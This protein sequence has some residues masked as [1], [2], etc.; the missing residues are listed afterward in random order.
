[1]FVLDL[2][3]YSSEFSVYLEMAKDDLKLGIV[4]VFLYLMHQAVSFAS[5]SKPWLKSK[6][7]ALEVKGKGMTV[8]L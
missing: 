3:D 2:Q 4:L 5:D 7:K 8:I 1:M 6:C